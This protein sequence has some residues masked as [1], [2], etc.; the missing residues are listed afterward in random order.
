[1]VKERHLL[2]GD[3]R[4]AEVA[5]PMEHR[6]SQEILLVEGSMKGA[7]PHFHFII[8]RRKCTFSPYILAFFHFDPYILILPLLVPKPINACLFRPFHQSTDRNI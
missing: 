7:T 5:P 6:A 3:I 8:F 4:Q 1:M 2:P